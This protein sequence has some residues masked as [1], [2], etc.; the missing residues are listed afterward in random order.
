MVANIPDGRGGR[1]TYPV[2][3]NLTSLETAFGPEE[4]RRLGD[5]LTAAYENAEIVYDEAIAF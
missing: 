2:P 3:F 5:K 4:G 1:I